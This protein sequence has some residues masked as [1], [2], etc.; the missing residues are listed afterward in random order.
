[1][2]SGKAGKTLAFMM[3]FAMVATMI[4]VFPVNH[5]SGATIY[6]ITGVVRDD[7]TGD[8]LSGVDVTIEN[9]TLFISKGTTTD[10]YGNYEIYVN[11]TGDFYINFTKIGYNAVNDMVLNDSFLNNVSTFSQ[12]LV[13]LPKVT[14]KILELGTNTPIMNVEVTINDGTDIITVLTLAD[15]SFSQYVKD[16]STLDITYKM[17]GYYFNEDTDV[18]VNGDKDL[19]EIYLEKIV[20]EPTITVWGIVFDKD[21]SAYV[22]GATVSI[23]TGDDKWITD[24]TDQNGKYEMLAYPGTFIVKASKAGYLTNESSEWL[25]VTSEKS[26]QRNIDLKTTGIEDLTLTGTVNDGGDPGEAMVYLYSTD[27]LYMNSTTT[28]GGA[29][30]INYYNSTFTQV[31][32]Q[33]GFF[34]EVF[35]YTI[36]WNNDTAYGNVDITLTQINSQYKLSGYITDAVSNNWIEGAEITLYDKANLYSNTTTSSPDGF[37]EFM[38]HGVSDFVM[39]VDAVGYQAKAI[40][41]SALT[42]DMPLQVDLT[43]S[44]VD[45][46][47]VSYTFADWQTISVVEK[48]SMAVDNVS[49]RVNIDRDYG[50]G[51]LGLTNNDWT[52]SPAEAADWVAYLTS[53]GQDNKDTAEFLNLD[54]MYYVLDDATPYTVTVEGVEGSAITMTDTINITKTYNYTLSGT[55]ADVEAHTLVLNA[56]Y[57]TPTMDMVYNVYLPGGFEMTSSQTETVLVTVEGYNDP[58]TIDTKESVEVSE[59]VTMDIKSSEAGTAVVEVT[60]GIFYELN[61]SAEG[62]EVIVSAP[63]D[64]V[65]TEVG[66]S[67]Q[68][69][70]DPVG[71][72]TAANFTWDL[73][74][75]GNYSYGI[76]TSYNYS[77]AGNFDLTLDIIE[78]GGDATSVDFKVLVDG[79]APVPVITVN[80]SVDN[81]SLSGTTLTVN[82]DLPIT[83]DGLGSYDSVATA[84]DK[85]GVIDSW[86]WVWGDG[87]V[88]ETV[89]MNEDGFINKTY[90]EPG[91]YTLEMSATDIVGHESAPKVFTVVVKDITAPDITGITMFDANMEETTDVLQGKLA[92]FSAND[93]SDNYDDFDDITFTW[94]FNDDGISDINGSWVPYTF[95]AIGDYNVTLTAIDK[96]GNSMDFVKV[97][98]VRIGDSANLLLQAATFS[99]D[100]EEGTVGKTTTISVNITN[101]GQLNATGVGVKF[102]IRDSNGNDAEISGTVTLEIN[103]ASTTTIGP[104]EIATASITWKPTKKGTYT[105]WANASTPDEHESQYSDNSNIGFW[106][107]STYT[108]AEAGWIV[109]AI[110]IGI[111][112][113]IIAVFFGT[114]YFMNSR[115]MSESKSGDKKKRK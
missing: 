54:G 40:P 7:V 6:T 17:D 34:T 1:M 57:D 95:P 25:T 96:T 28:V 52:I 31:V 58:I 45:T 84:T 86:F 91:R 114:R 26:E 8:T 21:T 97:V 66:F 82:E 107:Y 9:S 75:N 77:A 69:S 79:L 87:S 71:D 110:V 56:S 27:G 70:T 76:T 103:G 72:I 15:G 51:N 2:R 20:P 78:T 23:S 43:P 112:V 74:G 42:G 22:D 109:P 104:G 24:I 115:A 46:T 65:D 100:P 68:G 61:S 101:T 10:A 12:L 113:A 90:S 102:Y 38:V 44:D 94:D 36:D 5:V 53:K 105:I 37:Y 49:Q 39:V 33:D 48:T 63:Q 14:G 11:N 62:Y 16:G 41:I 83:F 13:P 18:M 80:T 4:A 55:A 50:M 98:N 64:G 30:T 85:M 73:M 59:T 3:A 32:K 108:V 19:G 29:Y 92:Y 81:V 47:T 89:T 106:E 111:I 35:G 67:A 93:T 88:N 60:D 99:F